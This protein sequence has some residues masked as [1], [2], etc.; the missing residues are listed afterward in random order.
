MGATKVYDSKAITLVLVALPIT[1]G[2]GDPFFKITPRGPAFED[3]LGIDGEVTRTATHECRYDW[4][5]T[6]KQSSKHNAELAAIHAADRESAGGAGIGA[7]LVKDN[8]GSSIYATDE[9]WITQMPD[10]QNGS[11]ITDVTWKGVAVISSLA[12]LPG[13][14]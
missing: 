1:D 14:N 7:L 11:K 12:A 2:K 13:G 9:C 6:L 4:E 5:C 3:D 10:W 8:N